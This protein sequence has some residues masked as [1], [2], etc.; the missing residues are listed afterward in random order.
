MAQAIQ[1]IANKID[2]FEFQKV[3]PRTAR[4]NNAAK[5]AYSVTCPN[6]RIIVWTALSVA[7][8]IWGSSQR[9]NGIRNRDVCSAESI[10]A[11]PIKISAIQR[12]AGIQYLTKRDHLM[13]KMSPTLFCN[14]KSA[15]YNLLI[16]DL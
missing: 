13:F 14:R 7:Q 1:T 4:H 5:M 16:S 9:K 11:D 2:I 6:L 15:I 12:I 3:P 8:V 10:S